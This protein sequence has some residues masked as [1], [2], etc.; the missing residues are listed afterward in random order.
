MVVVVVLETSLGLEEGRQQG[1]ELLVDQGV[2]VVPVLS[3]GLEWSEQKHL[4]GLLNIS[5][6]E[7]SL[8]AVTIQQPPDVCTTLLTLLLDMVV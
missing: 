7:H 3:L 6:G 8:C 5:K 4:R 1:Q 2:A